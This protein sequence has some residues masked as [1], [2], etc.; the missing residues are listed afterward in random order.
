[1]NVYL[2]N[3]QF[4]Q[5][6]QGQVN[7]WLPYSAGCLWAYV[8]QNDTIRENFVLRDIVFRRE[9]IDELV[10]RM[11]SPRVCGFSNYL[12]CRNWCLAAAEA[13][14]AQWP[15]CHIVFGGPETSVSY[16]SYDFV[17]TVVLAEGEVSFEDILIKIQQGQQPQD[18]YQKHRLENLEI[19]SPYTLGIFDPLIAA[20]PGIVWN[21]TIETNRG[22][23]YACTFC[24]WGSTTYSK[25]KKF[26]LERIQSELEWIA[27]NP[28]GFIFGA[29]ANFGIF[30]ER[31]L[32]IARMM[33]RILQG[34]RVDS[35]TM[36]FAKNSNEHI[37]EIANELRDYM[38]N[39]VTVS[40]QSM[41]PRVLQAIKRTNMNVNDIRD[42]M[43]L[44]R[45]HDIPTYSELII[46]L[47]E[48][49]L[50]SWKS[51]IG[52]I[53]ELGQHN[54]LRILMATPLENSELNLLQR[55]PYRI[56]TLKGYRR[57]GNSVNNEGGISEEDE[58]II[59]T[60]T[61]TT[62]EMIEGRL[63]AWIVASLHCHGYSQ[64]I[65]K[66]LRNTANV[67]Y[68]EFYDAVFARVQQPDSELYAIW[69]KFNAKLRDFFETGENDMGNHAI[70][71]ESFLL[72]YQN[73]HSIYQ[74]V[75][76]VAENFAEIPNSVH[77]LQR[78][79]IVE[80]C[81]YPIVYH[82]EY[83]LDTWQQT[84]RQ[85]TIS[86]WRQGVNLNHFDDIKELIKRGQIKNRVK[87]IQDCSEQS[88]PH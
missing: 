80:D 7:Y 45:E 86:A 24:D 75:A 73:R 3:P 82:S 69:S 54:N 57:V 20:N 71:H 13:I 29:D 53:L 27:Q 30:K 10:A 22:C 19:P 39:G 21:T 48:E 47:P 49:T 12:W 62:E 56:K 2:L 81:A 43:R 11:D 76:E 46:G 66:F 87:I 17:D 44:S 41:S 67:S 4:S 58:T 31:D 72:W 78:L 38:S 34:S 18:V 35:I 83:D 25:V 14:K 51:G 23:P 65:A 59:A 5:R 52:E 77:E 85:Y 26:N 36:Q 33:R 60:S 28:V 42:L 68:R 8:Q 9:H 15:E 55:L 40:V 50:E 32:E 74:L 79:F 1:M 37:F 6:F 64:I 63:Y 16:L 61:M 88:L 70:D 84:P